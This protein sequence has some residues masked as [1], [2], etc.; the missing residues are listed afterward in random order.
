M[1]KYFPRMSS[2]RE[3][4]LRDKEMSVEGKVINLNALQKKKQ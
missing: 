2:I 1:K 3:I 4:A